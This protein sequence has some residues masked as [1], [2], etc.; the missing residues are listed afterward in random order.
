MAWGNQTE[1]WGSAAQPAP[2]AKPVDPRDSMT[3]DEV[4]LEWERLKTLLAT[5][6]EQEMEY[7]KYVVSRAF[8]NANEGTNTVEL[9]NGYELKAG[10]KYNYKLDENPKVEAGLDAI[11]KIGNQGKFIADRLVSWTPNFQLTE[12]RKL[13]EEAKEGSKDAQ[14]ILKIA[15]S[16]LTITDAAPTLEIKAPKAKKQ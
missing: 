16:F 14:E 4:L 8:P 3:R 15:S 9:G 13:Q 1:G 2:Q 7:R 11:E 10:I 5:A 12:Y 6:K